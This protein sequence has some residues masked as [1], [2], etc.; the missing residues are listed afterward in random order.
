M[1]E[2]IKLSV[3]RG[4]ALLDG[5]Y[6]RWETLICVSI[7]DL[8]NTDSCILG[9]CYGSYHSGL[10]HLGLKETEQA[11]ENG[12]TLP[13]SSVIQSDRSKWDELQAAWVEQINLRQQ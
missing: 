5:Q 8:S 6:P 13:F 12:F 11:R 9:Q 1:D 10:S 3:K 7:L 2:D 4:A